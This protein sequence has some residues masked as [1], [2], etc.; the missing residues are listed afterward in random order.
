VVTVEDVELN[1][2]AVVLPTGTGYTLVAV[3]GSV[4]PAI[5]GNDYS[6]TLSLLAGYTQSEPIVKANGVLLT[7]ADGVYT[8]TDITDEQTVTVDGVVV[9]IYK[10]TLIGGTG[11]S[12]SSDCGGTAEHFTEITI[13]VDLGMGYGKSAYRIYANGSLLTDGK[14]IV[15]EDVVITV[16]G[17]GIDS[18]VVLTAAVAALFAILGCAL[19][20]PPK[21]P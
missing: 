10:V 17:V 13:T 12:I 15:T 7:G 8:I 6:F 16:E 9:N 19:F 5:H 14:L 21:K 1:V 11:Y 20:I 3:T 18:E 4:S 2:Y